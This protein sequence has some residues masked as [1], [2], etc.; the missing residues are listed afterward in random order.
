MKIYQVVRCYSYT[1][2]FVVHIFILT[3][4]IY[5][6]VDYEWNEILPVNEQ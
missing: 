3:N 4:S 2:I 6:C 1:D 5:H